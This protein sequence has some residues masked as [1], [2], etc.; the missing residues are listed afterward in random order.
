MEPDEIVSAVWI[1]KRHESDHT[2]YR[3]VGTRLA[4]AI[5][6]VVLGARLRIDEGVVTEARVA[7]GSVAPTPVRCAVVEEALVG[8]SV[9][10][11]AARLMGEDISP[12]DD[13]RSTARYR[14][15]VAA[16]VLRAWLETLRESD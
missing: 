14:S 8:R 12:I 9:D 4:Q 3:K 16:N 1:P 6:K 13:I 7:L 10:P 5:S 15:Q 2:H 11:E